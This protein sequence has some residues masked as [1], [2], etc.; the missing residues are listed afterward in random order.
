MIAS[1]NALRGQFTREGQSDGNPVAFDLQLKIPM[2]MRVCQVAF[3]AHEN[4]L[5]ISA[6]TG[7][8][9][10]IYDVA[11]L[12]QGQTR[13]A[14]ELSTNGAS[15]RALT[16]NPVP[17]KAD[18]FALVTTTGDLMMANLK[19]RKLDT[20]PNGTVLK[21]GV[22]CVSW[23]AKGKQLIAGLGNG[24]AFQMTPEGEGKGEIP[25][26]PGLDANHHGKPYVASSHPFFGLTLVVSSITWLGNDLFLIV[27]TPTA[28]DKTTAPD[29]IFHLVTGKQ[30][31]PYVFQKI[32]D[33][34][35][36]FGLNRSPPHHFLLRLRDFPPNL[37]DLLV[38]SSTASIDIGCLTRSESP[39]TSELPAEKITSVFT[40][41]GMADDSRRPQMRMTE[42]MVDLSPIGMAMD[43]SSKDTVLRPI[44]G[45]EIENSPTPLPALMVLDH[46]GVVSAW[47][48]VY[49]E[50]IRQGTA[51]PGLAAL[52]GENAT[53]S[54]QQT[55]AFAKPAPQTASAFGKLA[56]GATSSTPQAPASSFGATNLSSTASPAFG[57]NPALG[58]RASP[59]GT[60]SAGAAPRPGGATFG[61]P[62]FG[63]PTPVGM[64]AKTS[65][66]G[67]TSPLGHQSSPLASQAQGT[68][69]T[70]FGQTSGLGMRTGSVFGASPSN[71]ADAKGESKAPATSA[72]GGF[73]SY[74]SQGGFAAA[75]STSNAG[76]SIFGMSSNNAPTASTGTPSIFGV[77]TAKQADKTTGGGLNGTGSKFSLVST[78]KGDGTARDDDKMDK[79]GSGPP[80]SG[81]GSLL[82][83]ESP[84]FGAPRT[85][86]DKAAETQALDGT[87][88]D[89]ES[90]R[91]ESDPEDLEE[92]RSLGGE[93][94]SL[95]SGTPTLAKDQAARSL[96]STN[97][98]NANGGLFAQ[99]DESASLTKKPTAESD[100]APSLPP[101]PFPPSPKIKA[102]PPDEHDELSAVDKNIP[103]A[104]LPPDTVSKTT[105]AAGDS[106]TSSTSTNRPLV[107]DAP[108]PPDFV[109][110]KAAAKPAEDAPLP[111]DF[112][113]A[114][115]VPQ[116]PKQ[117]NEAGLPESEEDGGLDEEGSGVDVARDV[118]S[119][120]DSGQSVR[121]TP[122]SSFGPSVDRSPLGGSF[123]QISRPL[124]TQSSRPLF[125]EIGSNSVP[126]LPPPSSR[127]HQSPRSPSPVRSA[128]PSAMLRSD[129]S[130]S[131]SAPGVPSHTSQ[132]R[133][134]MPNILND[135]RPRP[136]AGTTE[137]SKG[138]AVPIP[139]KQVEEEDLSDKEDEK[140][141]EELATEVEGS[142]V[143]DPFIAHQDYV[144]HINKPGIPGQIERLY[145]DINSMIDT[146]GLNAR[147]LKSFIKG[148]SES[149]GDGGRSL[150][151][152]EAEDDWCLIEIDDLTYLEDELAAELDHGRVKDVQGK[153][154]TCTELW[155]NL[156]KGT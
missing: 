115:E 53:V 58:N 150:E 132:P 10:A 136:G 20:G 121:V 28:F 69:P 143:L 33:P 95:D 144:G 124:T 114:K 105:Y 138:E 128:V 109:S 47:W 96:Q 64:G 6:E 122:Q 152:L 44:A 98:K 104:P 133:K 39:L 49:S 52:K 79:D 142:T 26:P 118:S 97:F 23:S 139:P 3:S 72:S 24:T 77:P 11:A 12:M 5:L 135:S 34:C 127:V 71:V 111:P 90:D 56:F 92:R 14:F 148:H 21:Q 15:L 151:D 8:G 78:F 146:L 108:L 55:V 155:K 129:Q 60:P 80:F 91:S 40:T 117:V 68:P 99:P 61:T 100:K 4:F 57:A 110:S 137:K 141:R 76:G 45:E 89:T 46:E 101:A 140:I 36:P 18:M 83:E 153:L 35:P 106:S 131:F 156:I 120:T 27:H 154:D 13:S 43:L 145:R 65:A 102:E 82:S 81:L 125:G 22:S 66:F 63:S 87:E 37:R 116:G 62:A 73:G 134:I 9:L 74:A 41:T 84:A 147:S 70:S 38:V 93:G 54:T 123:T 50:S 149:F 88:M 59:W 107:D 113:T 86:V 112:I 25:V 94:L 2:Q 75:A 85:T 130:R 31:G 7:G 48:V 126:Y 29:S 67:S 30:P 16:P 19:E 119:M 32:A 103:E 17:E 42:D 51:Y 1:T